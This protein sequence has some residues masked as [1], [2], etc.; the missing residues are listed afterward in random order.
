MKKIYSVVLSLLLLLSCISTSV[1][2]LISVAQA[3]TAE[4][5]S[6]D[7]KQVALNHAGVNSSAAFFK[8]VTLERV[9][10]RLIYDVEFNAGGKSYEYQIDASTGDVI[11][12]DYKASRLPLNRNRASNNKMI[13]SDRAKEIAFSH[14][15]VAER[16]VTSLEITLD[17][18]NGTLTY[19]VN[20]YVG[21]V[22]YNYEINAANGKIMNY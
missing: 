19:N 17:K 12:F 4:I 10:G 9:D 15:G 7:A 18:D 6:E 20:F 3:A 22:P 21:S 14:A 5:T 16:D 11:G 13:S 8:K 2:P 1:T